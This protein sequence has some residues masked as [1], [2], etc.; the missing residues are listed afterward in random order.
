MG[1]FDKWRE[2]KARQRANRI[3]KAAKVVLNP[4]AIKEDRMASIQFLSSLDQADAEQAIRA[5]LPRFDYSLEHGI[6]DTREKEQALE[7]IV[8][9]GQLGIPVV[10]EKIKASNRIAWPIKILK[11][12][13]SEEEVLAILKDALDF[14]D[15][16]FNQ[17]IV[18][19]NYDVL[20][21]LRDYK[22]GEFSEKITHF[23]ADVDERV[24]FA[25]CEVLLEQ[26]HPGL[27]SHLEPFIGDT[28]SENNR[29]RQSV[30]RAFIANH[31]P[32]E[33]PEKYE[34]GFVADGVLVGKDGFLQG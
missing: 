4:K 18:D 1:L 17:A 31:W 7:G 11:K 2:M 32:L 13:G 8:R 12:V 24:R 19:K 6:V 10:K 33:H 5:L 34:N 15:V 23:L 26:K 20:C 28:S 16:S 9:H 29:I 27:A 22:L 25:A 3:K 30:I 21:Y 14:S